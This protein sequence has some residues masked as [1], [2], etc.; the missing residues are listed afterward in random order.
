MGAGKLAEQITQICSATLMEYEI[1]RLVFR[2]VVYS[3]VRM[4]FAAVGAC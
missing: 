1:L 4:F 2:T 3:S